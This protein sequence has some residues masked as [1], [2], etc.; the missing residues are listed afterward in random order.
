MNFQGLFKW[1]FNGTVTF[2]IIAT[3][4]L[5]VLTVIAFF[6]ICFCTRITIKVIL[7]TN[8]IYQCQSDPN[9]DRIWLICNRKNQ[10]SLDEFSTSRSRGDAF[11][12][13]GF[14]TIFS[15]IGSTSAHFNAS[16]PFKKGDMRDFE[17]PSAKERY[18]VSFDAKKK[19][20]EENEKGCEGKA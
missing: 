17:P 4:I 8:F 12:A 13:I 2:R 16:R 9:F 15:A 18:T 10:Q 3:P 7:Q 6:Q 11:I 14:G 1:K 19:N 20:V 5:T